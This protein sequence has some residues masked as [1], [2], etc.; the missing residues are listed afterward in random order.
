MLASARL[1]GLILYMNENC[2]SIGAENNNSK[3]LFGITPSLLARIDSALVSIPCDANILATISGVRMFPAACLFSSLAIA[4]LTKSVNFAAPIADI[5]P[6]LKP[7][8]RTI[9]NNPA[10]PPPIRSFF[11]S[12]TEANIAAS[13][14]FIVSSPHLT[15]FES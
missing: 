14:A 11:P 4:P 9:L 5:A 3:L 13:I 8:P 12:P 10:A 6:S 15:L 1:L 2:R 7:P